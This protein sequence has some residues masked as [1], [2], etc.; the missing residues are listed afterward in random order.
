[1]LCRPAEMAQ[2]V[3]M[4][5]NHSRPKLEKLVIVFAGVTIVHSNPCGQRARRHQ[6]LPV[7]YYDAATSAEGSPI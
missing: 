4:P 5:L 6:T 1:M 7:L 3:R 2:I